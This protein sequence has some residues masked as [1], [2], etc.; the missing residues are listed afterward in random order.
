MTKY[1]T[2]NVYKSNS[3][4]NLIPLYFLLI[5]FFILLIKSIKELYNKKK[6]LV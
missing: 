5:I 4:L 2:I 6:K 1:F 3:Y